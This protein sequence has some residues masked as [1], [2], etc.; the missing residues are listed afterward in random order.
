MKTTILCMSVISAIIAFSSCK[1]ENQVIP[2]AALVAS[3]TTA[4]SIGE[5]VTF[6]TSRLAVT[7][8]VTWS[9]SPDS[10]VIIRASDTVALFSFKQPGQYTVTAR[11]KGQSK[12]QVVTV[13]STIYNFTGSKDSTYTNLYDSTSYGL[14]DSIA[15][16]TGDQIKIT[17]AFD[18]TGN[19]SLYAVTVKSYLYFNNYLIS[20]LNFSNNTSTINYTGVYI[21]AQSNGIAGQQAAFTKNFVIGSVNGTYNLIINLNGVTYKGT[22]TKSGNTATFIWPYNSG[23]TISPLTITK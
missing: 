11:S 12:S 3:K 6:T 1:K 5:P 10:N 18:T 20:D 21:P 8:S 23:I 13:S 14:K 17:P 16:L 19:V 9:V 7:D 2:I 22:Y 4:I 15:A